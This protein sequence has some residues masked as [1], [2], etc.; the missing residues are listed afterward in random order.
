MKYKTKILMIGLGCVF[1]LLVLAV[2]VRALTYQHAMCFAS[3]DCG[4][5]TALTNCAGKGSGAS[6][7]LCTGEGP[8]KWCQGMGCLYLGTCTWN[9]T[10]ALCGHA[11]EGL[12][13]R[14]EVKDVGLVSMCI[15][16]NLTTEVCTGPGCD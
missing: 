6:C 5:D 4:A 3:G 15:G 1:L 11:W 2:P 14:V 9:G 13:Y 12:C 8:S 7:F 16:A 10:T